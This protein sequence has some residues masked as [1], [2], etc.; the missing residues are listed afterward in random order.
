MA[1]GTHLGAMFGVEPTGRHVRWRQAHVVR[2]DNHRMAEHWG[3]SDLA[4]LW[5]QIGKAT[6]DRVPRRST[7]G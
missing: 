7:A 5:V 4:S 1:E 3:I 2:M 6:M